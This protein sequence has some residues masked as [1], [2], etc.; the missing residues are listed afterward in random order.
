MNGAE[1]DAHENANLAH[2]LAAL[3]EH[4]EW[5]ASCARAA[6]RAS[7][8]A[9]GTEAAF[10]LQ[11]TSVLLLADQCEEAEQITL[12]AV[13]AARERGSRV[14]ESVALTLATQ[15][16]LRRGDLMAAIG[17]G[18]SS[19]DLATGVWN[20]GS[21]AWMVEA[22]AERGEHVRVEELLRQHQLDRPR[23]IETSEASPGY[24]LV[25]LLYHRARARLVRG[26]HALALDDL[27]T[28][29]E[30]AAVW[31]VGNPSGF[32]WRSSSARCLLALG[33]A[34]EALELARDELSAAR[35]WDDRTSLGIALRTTGLCEAGEHGVQLLREAV[36]VHAGSPAT[37]ERARS[38]VW[39]G[40]R[41]RRER[42]H[43][44]ARDL[45]RRGLD[46]A[47]RC[48]AV[49]LAG[50]ARDELVAAGGKPRRDALAGVEALTGRER[51]IAELGAQ[52]MTNR[53]IAGTLFLSP[54]T[55]EHH[56]RNIYRKLGI[57]SR[58][59]LPDALT[60]AA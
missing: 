1:L 58:E 24:Q 5:A 35:E 41:L 4:R 48:G 42:Q 17:R 23:L 40:M 8:N 21:I 27:S 16:A 2:E 44:E 50:Q 33:R 6:I 18:Q 54:R 28:V 46:G 57:R 14:D 43:L 47:H 56:L 32:D 13:R 10:V 60:K 36:E 37:L 19:L 53:D 59:E 9:R 11:L 3:G 29:G 51:R 25:A 31:G 15:S 30:L 22:L 26:D 38:Q 12:D 39:L 7:P 45:L 20:V 52:G 49:V 55:V 34:P